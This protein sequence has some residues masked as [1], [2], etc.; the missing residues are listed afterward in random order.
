[1]KVV[2]K[3]TMNAFWIS[4]ASIYKTIRRVFYAVMTFLGQK[5]IRLPTTEEFQEVQELKMAI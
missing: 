5:L 4:R 2:I 3:K 1:M